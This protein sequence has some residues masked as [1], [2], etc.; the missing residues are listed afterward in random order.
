MNTQDTYRSGYAAGWNA[1]NPIIDEWSRMVI[2][3]PAYTNKT[4]VTPYEKGYVR[5]WLDS[6]KGQ[7]RRFAV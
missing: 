5:G 7:P 4:A 2:P 1:T 3:A 6:S